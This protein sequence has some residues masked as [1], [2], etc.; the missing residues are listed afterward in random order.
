VAEKALCKGET[1]VNICHYTLSEI[2]SG[3]AGC[4]TQDKIISPLRTT[5]YTKPEYG[6]LKSFLKQK[7]KEIEDKEWDEVK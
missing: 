2:G 3:C 4:P 1:E 7:I 6:L 5:N